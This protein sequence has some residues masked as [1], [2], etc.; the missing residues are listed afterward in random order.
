MFDE[1]CCNEVDS[2][3]KW[4]TGNYGITTTSRIEFVLVVQDLQD[5]LRDGCDLTAAEPKELEEWRTQAV[6]LEHLI[7]GLP[8]AG[9]RQQ[10]PAETINAGHPRATHRTT[11]W[12][13]GLADLNNKLREALERPLQLAEAVALCLY[14]G[15]LF[16]KYN[17]VCRGGPLQGKPSPVMRNKFLSLCGE[18][19]GSADGKVNR[20]V[21]T[22]HVL[23]SALVKASKVS[24]AV[25]VMRGTTGGKLP[26]KFWQEDTSGVKGGVEYGF[27]STTTDRSVAMQYASDP[28]KGAGTVLEIQTGMIDKGADLSW[29]SQYPHERELCFP[30]LTSLQVLGTSVEGTVLVVSLRLNLNLTSLT[31]EEV[32]GKRK[33]IV[34]GMCEN[35]KKE[36]NNFIRSGVG[37]SDRHPSR[38]CCKLRV[39]SRM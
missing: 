16:E 31:I 29:I 34:V 28:T 24:R 38:L 33:K 26:D 1:H 8:D 12:L 13:K 4:T 39:C 7:S 35:L 3:R 5:Q 20:Y 18:G 9:P 23:A 37:P 10:W 2:M 17:H 25:T 21:T 6:R 30:P 22:I 36:C 11:T 14:T 15:P 27:M 19:D 32:I